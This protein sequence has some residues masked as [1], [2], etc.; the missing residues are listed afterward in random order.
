MHQ[1]S[2]RKLT[3]KNWKQRKIGAH[4]RR[5]SSLTD[6]RNYQAGALRDRVD[7]L[8]SD[9]SRIVFV[10]MEETSIQYGYNFL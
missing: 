4:I 3:V 7:I 10:I 5:C 1:S 2:R 9:I 8:V 6:E